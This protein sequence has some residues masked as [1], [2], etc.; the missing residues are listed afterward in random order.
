LLTGLVPD[1]EAILAALE[2]LLGWSEI[3]RSPQLARF[4]DYIVR[5][6]LDG[7]EQTIKAYSIAVDVFGRGTDFD[8]QADPIVR[9]QA[10]RLRGLLDD[11][12]R[13][14]G[15]EETTQISLPVGR[16]I[17]DFVD[18]SRVSTD[19]VVAV[20]PASAPSARLPL[21]WYLLAVFALMTAMTAYATSKWGPDEL[22][23]ES[24]ASSTVRRPSVGV[25]EF[26]NLSADANPAPQVAGLAIE[27][28][29]DLE[30]SDNVD[31]R[32]DSAGATGMMRAE[33]APTDYV[34]TGIARNEGSMMRYSAILTERR[35][36]GVAWSQ[37]FS[38]PASEASGSGVLDRVSRAF[39]LVLGS[40]R[41]PLHAATREIILGDVEP[42]STIY[43]CRALFDYYR[44]TGAG[45][46]AERAD[47]CFA[48]LPDAERQNPI[49]L[50]ATASL[51]AEYGNPTVGGDMTPGERLRMAEAN[52]DLAVGLNPLSGF[53]WE[54]QGRLREA[55]GEIDEA[56]ADYA[57][58]VQLNPA[59]T[60]ALAVFARLLAFSGNLDEAERM[61]RDAAERS[62]NPPAWY[63]GVPALLDLRDGDFASALANAE[64]YAQADPELGAVL[65]IMAGQQQGDGALV[66]RHLNDVLALE[67]FRDSGVLPRLSQRI[68]DMDLIDRIGAALA[69]A[70]VPQTSL[71][72]AF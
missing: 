16:Y 54:Q 70:G 53:V 6:K 66:S 67:S 51:L 23:V 20:Q 61:A 60:D 31:V 50:A 30:Q 36:G 41:G 64:I 7:D 24:V 37:S 13:G 25:V 3:A 43:F 39:T 57:S 38:I 9:V 34:L 58:S 52:L 40:P 22:V 32:Y 44:E 46:D 45:A 35:T 5:R 29:T 72:G 12:Y 2:R 21:T 59:N 26:S 8:P 62:P 56:R 68:R 42:A 55:M 71:N 14:P 48:A 15:S 4:L 47:R 69:Q 65:A 28:V 49:A 11:Y 1:R 63:H 18:V 33:L 27:L 17:P 10:R 19:L